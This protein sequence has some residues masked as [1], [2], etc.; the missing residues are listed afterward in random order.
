MKV[1]DIMRWNPAVVTPNEAVAHAAE[2][3][4][5]ERDACIPVVKDETGRVLVGVI[6][7]RDIATRCVARRHGA[8]CT[9]GDHMTPMPLHTVQPDDEIGPMLHVMHG[10]EIRRLPVVSADG[11]IMG[12]VTEAEVAEAVAHASSL[13]VRPWHA[14]SVQPRPRADARR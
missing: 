4:R 11:V 14:P 7:A 9:V 12:M 2:H 5:Y 8:D 3:M 10:A 13:P 1:R 6:T